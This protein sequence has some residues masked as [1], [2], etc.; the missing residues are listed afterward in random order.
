MKNLLLVL[1][2]LIFAGCCFAIIT[3]N[4]SKKPTEEEIAAKKEYLKSITGTAIGTKAIPA[5]KGML[6]DTTNFGNAVGVEAM[7]NQITPLNNTAIG[8][9]GLSNSVRGNA[10]YSRKDYILEYELSESGS[11]VFGYHGL[12]DSSKNNMKGE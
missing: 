10:F 3:C 12:T 8:Y 2:L 5:A 1:G 6:P 9:H 11:I 7:K 4:K